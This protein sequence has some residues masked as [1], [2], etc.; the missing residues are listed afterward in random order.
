MSERVHGE[1][2]FL[3]VTAGAVS[4][5]RSRCGYWKLAR[6]VVQIA[7]QPCEL[8]SR[9][10]GCSPLLSLVPS[11]VRHHGRRSESSLGRH[12]RRRRSRGDSS[13]AAGHAGPCAQGRERRRR[14]PGQQHTSLADRAKVHCAARDCCVG[15]GLDGA[16]CLAESP[17]D[18]AGLGCSPAAR[19][20]GPAVDCRGAGTFLDCNCLAPQLSPGACS[21]A[22]PHFSRAVAS[23]AL[24]YE[25]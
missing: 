3:H 10:L 13:R 16:G 24:S 23:V 25:A 7:A 20:L 21:D 12:R 9:I 11:F 5:V 6:T 15:S 22:A 2:R 4:S 17:Q 18:F 1:S 14:L 8:G 19:Q